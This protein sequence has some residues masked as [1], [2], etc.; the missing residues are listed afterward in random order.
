MEDEDEE[1]DDEDDEESK[2]KKT[3]TVWDWEL[4]NESKAIWLRSPS[5]IVD[6]EYQSFYKALGKVL[7]T[8][9]IK[10]TMH[11]ASNSVFCIVVNSSTLQ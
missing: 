4:Q 3:E 9:L 7:F 10:A 6:D 2:E 1:G 11:S 5:E 8:C